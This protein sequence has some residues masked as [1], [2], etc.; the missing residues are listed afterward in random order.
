[1]QWLGASI[2]DLAHTHTRRRTSRFESR[3]D[4]IRWLLLSFSKFQLRFLA[5]YGKVSGVSRE[6]AEEVRY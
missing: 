1:M 2:R 4:S 6:M 5:D 3:V